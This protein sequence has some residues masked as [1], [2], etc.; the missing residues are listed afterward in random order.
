MTA[1][2]VR[3]EYTL[4]FKLEAVRQVRG[5]QSQQK[6]AQALGIPKASLSNW[7]RQVNQGQFLAGVADAE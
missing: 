1:R 5:G 3:A 4:E 2:K 7:V 6:V